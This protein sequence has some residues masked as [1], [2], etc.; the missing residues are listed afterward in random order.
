V[1]QGLRDFLSPL[2]GGF[3]GTGWPLNKAVERLELWAV[4]TRV[5]GVAKVNGVLLTD[6]TGASLDRVPIAG[7]Q[8]PRLMGLSVGPGEPQA[9]D[10]L[11]GAAPPSD[12]K[13]VVPVPV[14]PPECR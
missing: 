9:L 5:E 14:V 10:E 7:L 4:A 2:T 3:E 8:L 1:E 12:G 13:K 6:S 11:R